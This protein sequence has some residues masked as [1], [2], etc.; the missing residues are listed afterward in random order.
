MYVISLHCIVAEVVA[1]PPSFPPHT[2]AGAS[3]GV[4]AFRPL[5]ALSGAGAGK[6]LIA[7]HR[8]GIPL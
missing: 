7:A 8:A 3:A 1:D 6:Q 4:W 2:G 5:A